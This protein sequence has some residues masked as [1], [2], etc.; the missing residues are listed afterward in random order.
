MKLSRPDVPTS[1]NGWKLD[2]VI[3][4]REDVSGVFGFRIVG[5]HEVN[6]AVFANTIQERIRMLQMK[7][8]PTNVRNQHTIGQTLHLAG[9][10]IESHGAAE[11]FTLAKQQLQA[12]A[13][14]QQRCS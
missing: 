1:R 3:G 11:L 4:C 6:E 2:I 12:Q 13:Q 7:L 5:V 9:Y 10:E 14:A 8:V